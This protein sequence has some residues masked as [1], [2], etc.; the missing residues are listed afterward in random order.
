[1]VRMTES[2]DHSIAVLHQALSV[3]RGMLYSAR[4]GDA[5]QA[6]IER[7]LN[8]TTETSLKSLIGEAAYADAVRLAEAL[9][10]ET[11]DRL[12]GVTAMT[13]TE[14]ATT[15]AHALVAHDFAAA[16]ALLTTELQAAYSADELRDQLT[17]MLAYVAHDGKGAQVTV[18]SS[19]DDWPEKQAGDAGWAYVSIAGEA[20]N[21]SF[22]EAVTVIVTNE[23]R[24]RDIVWGRP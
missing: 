15:F 5:T 2:K 19:M 8:S 6:E 14:I 21:Q 16:H 22:A 1:M 17:Q 4:T 18:D 20:A 24:I 11:R 12:L 7:I 3:A 9:P 13:Y 23:A 10:P